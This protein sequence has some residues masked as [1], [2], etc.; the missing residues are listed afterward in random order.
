MSPDDM[1]DDLQGRLVAFVIQA[2][3][4]LL[5]CVLL[6]VWLFAQAVVHVI[7][8]QNRHAADLIYSWELSGFQILFA[9]GT[10]GI[11]GL[12]IYRDLHILYIRTRADIRRVQEKVRRDD[13]KTLLHEGH[14]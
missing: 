1:G 7:L 12:P 6:V 11:I 2:F 10:L 3:S 5:D 13:E 4:I 14:D 8:E 9:V